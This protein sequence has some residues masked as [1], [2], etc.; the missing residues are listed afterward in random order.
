MRD[1]YIE[2]AC[3]TGFLLLVIF[4]LL[5][6]IGYSGYLTDTFEDEC[7][8]LGGTAVMTIQRDFACVP[9]SLILM[10]GESF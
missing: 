4:S 7:D 3:M 6:A 9:T 8:A 10:K 1:I 5:G 2:E